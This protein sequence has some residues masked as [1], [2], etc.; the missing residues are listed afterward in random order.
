MK[1]TRLTNLLLALVCLVGIGQAWSGVG[2][3]SWWRYAAALVLVGLLYEWLM[4]RA[5]AVRVAV[6]RDSDSD[7]D[8]DS[9]GDSGSDARGPQLKLGRPREIALLFDND[10]RVDRRVD[11]LTDLPGELESDTAQQQLLLPA[12]ER[13]EFR[14]SL[15]GRDI[16]QF[17]WRRLPARMRGPLGLA[18]WPF[19][20]SLDTTFTVAPDLSGRQVSQRG[21]R[22]Q[23]EH[24]SRHGS[25][26]ELHHLREYVQ[27]DP[28]HSIHWKATARS[29]RLVTRVMNEEQRL[30]IMLVLDI[31][32]TSKTRV[33][34]M[35]QFGHYVNLA[36]TFSRFALAN[37]DA[38]GLVASAHRPVLS[39]PPASGPRASVQLHAAL[40]R[41]QPSAEE[42][43]MLA[44]A[45][46]VQ[47]L[48]RKRSLV[49]VLTD[50]YSQALTGSFGKSL[51]LWSTRHL[52][53]V[54]GLVGEDVTALATRPAAHAG[55]AY[56]RLAAAEYRNSL[57]ANSEAVKRL[58]AR[59]VIARPAELHAS[60]MEEYRQ[61]KL[62]RGV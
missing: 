50:L 37:G 52:P 60:V 31:G 25:G 59:A 30:E 13:T 36:A 10:G 28:L 58:G 44:T 61:L 16:G 6:D 43:D 18:W 23:G 21:E 55:D 47:R 62:R 12:G 2:G 35:S 19:P 48:A 42:V 33:D 57:A 54:V 40:R 24:M 15:T 7:S 5:A 49:I 39:L 1:L 14:L 3:I 9:D 8:G 11:F 38:V 32:R 56:A 17:H 20:L 53:F 4:V 34:G 29:E 45:L 26:M 22:A 41:L 27:G 51:R 46:E